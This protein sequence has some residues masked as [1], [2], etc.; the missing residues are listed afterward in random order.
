VVQANES[1]IRCFFVHTQCT[2]VLQQT[3]DRMEK[4]AGTR[5]RARAVANSSSRDQDRCIRVDHASIASGM[6]RCGDPVISRRLFL[7]S[8]GTLILCR[9]AHAQPAKVSRIGYLAAG[10]PD[11]ARLLQAFLEGLRSL[12]YV[13]G[14]NIIIEHRT[15]NGR[16][17]TLPRLAQELVHLRV[18]VIV[19]PTTPVAR[20]AQRATSFIPIVFT[21]VSDPVGSGLVTSLSR[22][23][24]NITGM[25]DMDVGVVGKRL[26]LLKQVVPAVKR[27]GALGNPTDKVWEPWWKQAQMAARRLHIDLVP[28]LITT[29]NELESAFTGLDRRVEALLVAPQVFLGTHRRRVIELIALARLPSIHERRALPEAGALMSYGPN[30]GAL[31]RQAARHVDKILKGTRP[32]DLPVEEPTEYEFVINLKTAKA[33]GLRVPQSVLATANEVIR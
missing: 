15:A 30:Y 7:T 8:A 29:A 18:D 17:E 11:D 3:G 25:S 33:L 6:R 24:G 16:F 22:P 23:G 1:A 12:G 5:D 19:A 4:Q 32:A 26:D 31:L 28:V 13:E 20:A 21:I 2:A 10:L 9:L 27:V 14:Q